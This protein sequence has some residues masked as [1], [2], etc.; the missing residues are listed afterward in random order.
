MNRRLGFALLGLA[1]FAVVVENVIVF[2]HVL[3]P[4]A[5]V[6]TDDFEADEATDGSDASAME[7]VTDARLSDYVD[8][9]S[10][11]PRS[12]FL[13]RSEAEELDSLGNDARDPADPGLTLTGT[14]WSRGQRIAWINGFPLAEGDTIDSRRI[15]HIERAAV[16]LS[17]N[18]STLRIVVAPKPLV[19][20]D[21]RSSDAN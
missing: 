21:G 5:A 1:A 6:S 17:V 18:G 14:L 13:T 12:P 16:L 8:G 3:M 20:G 4:R 7:P 19:D 15:E 11:R 9:L 2:R 10:G